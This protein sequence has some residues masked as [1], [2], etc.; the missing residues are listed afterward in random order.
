VSDRSTWM[1]AKPKKVRPL[2]I[3]MRMPDDPTRVVS[4][5]IIKGPARKLRTDVAEPERVPCGPGSS[6]QGARHAPAVD[7][8]ARG[9]AAVNGFVTEPSRSTGGRW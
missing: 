5:I 2:I 6:D 1:R 7:P 4:Q 9:L 3:D 8:L